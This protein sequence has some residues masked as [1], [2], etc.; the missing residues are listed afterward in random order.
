MQTHYTKSFKIEAVKRYLNRSIG[1]TY[2]EVAKSLGTS[3]TS[4]YD[5]VKQMHDGKMKEG[6]TSG[7]LEKRPQDWTS[8]EKFDA[9][10]EVENMNEEETN[11]YCRGKGIF[12]HH[13]QAWKQEFKEGKRNYC[14]D[15]NETKSLKAEI[16]A[17]QK[18][19]RRKDKALA[20]AAALLVLKK[21]VHE[22]WGS[23]EEL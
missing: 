19:L 18:E 23:D 17:L 11:S 14:K 3:K 7:P 20:E 13:L 16:K 4:L 8:S 1:E 15:K 5:W 10:L 6:A 12:P 2:E 22:I 21:K 9:I